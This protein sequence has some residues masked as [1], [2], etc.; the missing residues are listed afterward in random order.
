[1]HEQ[2]DRRG[3]GCFSSG[4]KT[5]AAGTAARYLPATDLSRHSQERIARGVIQQ[6]ALAFRYRGSDIVA[7]A[8]AVS[9]AFP[10]EPHIG[11]PAA[12]EG[13]SYRMFYLDPNC[14]LKVLQ[15]E[16][17]RCR[18]LPFIPS[19]PPD[20]PTRVPASPIPSAK[21]S[22]P[23]RPRISQFCFSSQSSPDPVLG[24]RT[25]WRFPLCKCAIV[26][27]FTSQRRPHNLYVFQ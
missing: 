26:R 1:M 24:I 9:L 23:A 17:P 27:I 5:Q 16:N 25:S 10:G 2:E 21:R 12:A 14:V 13:W 8:G 4:A 22:H 3:R 7:P 11:A 20:S 15:S 6:E 19:P 18:S